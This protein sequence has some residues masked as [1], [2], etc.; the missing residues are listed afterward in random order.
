MAG[1][2]TIPAECPHCREEFWLP[3]IEQ[4]ISGDQLVV[5]F[6]LAQ[7]FDHIET[8]RTVEVPTHLPT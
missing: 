7:L 6:D 8:H 2:A 4:H 5:R 1:F 3:V